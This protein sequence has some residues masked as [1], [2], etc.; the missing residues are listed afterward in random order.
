MRIGIIADTHDRVPAVA[1]LLRKFSEAGVT[2]VLHAGDYCSPFALAPFRDSS[3][4][5]AG[6][7]GNND[8]DHEGIKAF[9]AT[10]MGSELYDAPHSVELEGER[11]LLVHE[12][13]DAAVRSIASHA[14]VVHAGTHQYEVKAQGDALLVNPGE[15]CGWLYGVP[16]AAILDLETKHVERLELTGPEWRV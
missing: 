3:I 8:G 4:A 11:I 7:F 16:T 5:M 6:V 14:I 2:F 15:S 1:E 12:L 13:N 9:A 10:S